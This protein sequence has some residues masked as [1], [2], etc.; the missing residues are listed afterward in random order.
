VHLGGHRRALGTAPGQHAR[1]HRGHVGRG[2]R[3][4]PEDLPAGRPAFRGRVGRDRR[5]DGG[6][7]GVGPVPAVG[8]PERGR[9]GEHLLRVGQVHLHQPGQEL[10]PGPLADGAPDQG[11]ARIARSPRRARGR[12]QPG[13][14]LP[15][16]RRRPAAP[17]GRRVRRRGARQRGPDV[18]ERGDQAAGQD[19]LGLP[20]PRQRRNDRCRPPARQAVGHRARVGLPGQVAQ[21]VGQRR[22]QVPAVRGLLRRVRR[23]HHRDLLGQRQVAHGPLEHHP[24]QGGLHGGRRG[25]QLVKEQQPAP[26]LG[27]PPRPGRGSE[28]DLAADHDGQPGEV[29]R[30]PDRRDDRLAGQ[31]HG[32][33]HG[34]DRGRLAGPWR[35]PQQHRHPSRDRHPQRLHG[36]VA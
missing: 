10:H 3:G 26:G 1:G 13:R 18:Q 34:P 8:Q 19:L 27:Q 17:R 2:V 36:R 21:P 25:G 14:H 23:G 12:H 7:R 20:P 6:Q 33:G 22:G 9:V 29:R 32:L 35:A 15:G 28:P 11:R 5:R 30:F 16:P 4:Q 24:E 31:V